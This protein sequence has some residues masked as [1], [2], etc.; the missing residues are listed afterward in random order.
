MDIDEFI[1]QNNELLKGFNRK[2]QKKGRGNISDD[3]YIWQNRPVIWTD[4]KTERDVVYVSVYLPTTVP[5]FEHRHKSVVLHNHT[6]YEG[7]TRQKF[8]HTLGWEVPEIY[9]TEFYSIWGYLYHP[10]KPPVVN[11]KLDLRL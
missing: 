5:T 1:A 9:H 3:I 7:C 6:V 4:W 10:D 2:P 8:C 11:V